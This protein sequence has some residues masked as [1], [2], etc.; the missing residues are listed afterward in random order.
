M[1][2]QVL[3]LCFLAAI[4]SRAQVANN[5]SL[6]GTVTDANGVVMGAKVTAVN[7]GTNDTYS[8]TTDEQGNY[9]ITFVREGTYTIT[10]E[11]VGFRNP[12]SIKPTKFI[13]TTNGRRRSLL[14]ENTSPAKYI[15]AQATQSC[16]KN[17]RSP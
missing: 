3:F 8:A 1:Q 4:P 7:A 15:P 10:T 12:C 9:S 13:S 5:T 2:M 11:Q 6:V 17:K 14:R 16:S